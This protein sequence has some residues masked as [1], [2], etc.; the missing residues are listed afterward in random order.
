LVTSSAGEDAGDSWRWSVCPL[1]ISSQ[2]VCDAWLGALPIRSLSPAQKRADLWP[3][4]ALED[5]AAT[6]DPR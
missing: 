2:G 6:R 3:P 5:L 1:P 4:A